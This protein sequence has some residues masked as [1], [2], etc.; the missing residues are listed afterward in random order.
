VIV[1]TLKARAAHAVRATWFDDHWLV[2]DNG[3]LL[4]VEDR[5]ILTECRQLLAFTPKL[6]VRT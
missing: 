3:R 6:A 1:R 4:L 5:E 2:L